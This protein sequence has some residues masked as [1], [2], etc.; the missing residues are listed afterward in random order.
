MYIQEIFEENNFSKI[1]NLIE[2]NSLGIIVTN[3]NDLS[4]NH[5][6]FF[7]KEIKK[8]FFLR[9]HVSSKNT[10]LNE[11]S[12]EKDVLVIFNGPSAYISPSW[13]SKRSTSGKVQPTWVYRVVHAYCSVKIINDKKWLQ[14]HLEESV[15]F[16]EKNMDSPWSLTEAP[17]SFIEN[18]YNHIVGLEL[19]IKKL[20]SKSQ[21][22]QQRCL[23]DKKNAIIKLKELDKSSIANLLLDYL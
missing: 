17:I 8:D 13:M 11:I 3:N 14:Q 23:Q 12:E 7:F 6:P 5:L 10:I 2:E 16:F 4:A 22:L 21:L 9:T 1:K 18:L 20:V 19:K 15:S